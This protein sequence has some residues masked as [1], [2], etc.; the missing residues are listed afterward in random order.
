ME[1]LKRLNFSLTP[2]RP[3]QTG[4]LWSN[5]YFR[6]ILCY[7]KISQKKGNFVMKLNLDC[8]RDI[9]LDIED[10]T[11]INKSCKYD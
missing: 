11:S 3:R 7:I 6:D 8:I 10:T 4:S 9:L 1:L 2:F 5:L